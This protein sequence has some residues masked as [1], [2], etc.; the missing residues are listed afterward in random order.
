[1]FSLPRWW[2]RHASQIAIFILVVGIAWFLRS[3]QSAPILEFYR[4][5]VAPWQSQQNQEE[6][7][8]NARIQELQAQLAELQQQNQNLEKLLG[9]TQNQ[10]QPVIAAP[11]IGRSPNSWWQQVVIGKGS[12]DG[13]EKGFIVTGIGGLVGRVVAV[14][15]HTSKILLI[16]DPTSRVGVM[17]SRT[18]Y[19]GFIQGQG[20][21]KAV[22]N[23]FEKVPD[24]RVGDVVITSAV[25]RLFPPGLPVGRVKSVKV[26]T[27]PAPEAVV[28]LTAPFNTLEWVVVHAFKSR[29]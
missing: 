2:N 25:S 15:P 23:F 12:R 8:T 24:I 26:N 10:E 29:I 18:R 21:N 5:L 7:L 20:S 17:I 11:I 28:E 13:I 3:S 16:S 9:Y 6:S 27:G 1:M 14:T 4:L 22:M 19:M